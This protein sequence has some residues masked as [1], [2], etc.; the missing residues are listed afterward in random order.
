VSAVQRDQIHGRA[1]RFIYDTIVDRDLI[2]IADNVESLPAVPPACE[3]RQVANTEDAVHKM[4]QLLGRGKARQA[5]DLF[6]QNKYAMYLE[7]SVGT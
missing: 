1:A 7:F 4:S 5:P 2:I 3:R 6:N